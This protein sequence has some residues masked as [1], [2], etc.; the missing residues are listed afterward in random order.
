MLL[1]NVYKFKC[2]LKIQQFWRQ[3]QFLVN[4]DLKRRMIVVMQQY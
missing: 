1:S 3:G 2:T 4:K